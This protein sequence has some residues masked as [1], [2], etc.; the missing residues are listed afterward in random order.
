MTSTWPTVAADELLWVGG[1]EMRAVDKHIFDELGYSIFQTVE[2]A[3]RSLAEV[4]RGWYAPREAIVLVG[5]GGNG[6]GGLVAARHLAATGVEVTV[7]LTAPRADF[8][9]PAGVLLSALSGFEVPVVD[10]PTPLA[11]LGPGGDGVILDAMVGYSLQGE[12]SGP[13]RERAEQANE[14]P[15]PVL[16]LDNP[17]GVSAD[18]GPG[19]DGAGSLPAGAIDAD[20]TMT[21]S[22]PKHGLRDLPGELFIADTTIPPTAVVAVVSRRSGHVPSCGS[23]HTPRTPPFYLGQILRVV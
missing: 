12:L 17:S 19:A 1:E 18:A 9:G 11:E 5:R 10:D 13:A 15:W 8:D 7:V 2:N 14:H 20:A 3:G 21:L 4:T 6:L 22:L 16:A 23:A